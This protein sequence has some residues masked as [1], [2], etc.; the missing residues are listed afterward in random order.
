MAKIEARSSD[1][2]VED[3]TT[4]IHAVFRVHA[5]WAEQRAISRISCELRSLE[6][7]GCATV[8]A[9]AFGLLAF[10]LCHGK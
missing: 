10:W 3:L 9:A 2:D 5:M 8:S 7:V 6:S 1:L 4:A